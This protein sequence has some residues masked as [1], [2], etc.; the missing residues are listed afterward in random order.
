MNSVNL[1]A[2]IQIA[3][4]F[5]FGLVYLSNSHI[6][7]NILNSFLAEMEKAARPTLGEAQDL[8]NRTDHHRQLKVRAK[9]AELADVINNLKYLL[10]PANIRWDKYAYT[11]IY[12]GV[13]G[14]LCLLLIGLKDCRIDSFIQ[15]FLLISGEVILFFQF[16]NL[17]QLS[18]ISNRQISVIKVMRKMLWLGII[19]VVCALMVVTGIYSRILQ[20]FNLPFVLLT[21][22]IVYFPFLVYGYRIF[23]VWCTIKRKTSKCASLVTQLEEAVGQLCPN[24]HYLKKLRKSW[25]LR[26]TGRSVGDHP[27]EGV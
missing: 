25:P 18:G 20:S 24:S 6:F 5:D 12:S 2:F 8:Y 16:L 19:L 17:I 3:V 1:L 14:L 23:K 26:Y 7:T 10:D 15:N 22:S 13:Y 4:A 27:H 9:R 11:G 21:I